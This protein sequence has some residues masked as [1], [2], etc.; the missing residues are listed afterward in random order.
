MGEVWRRI[1]MHPGYEASSLGRVRSV[2]RTL[3]DGRTAGGVVLAQQEDKDGYLRVKLGRK[4]IGVHTLVLLAFHGPPEAR[5]LNGN[6]QD[7]RPT[8]LAWGSRRDNEQDKWKAERKKEEGRKENRSR[9]SEITTSF[10]TPVRLSEAHSLGV[11]TG[12]LESVRKCRHRD[13]TFPRPVAADG[14][15]MLY[16][17][18]EL[19][20][21]DRHRRGL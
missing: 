21:W 17:A 18:A 5:H 3:T 13:E 11:V 15:A 2:D 20:A 16:D 4:L 14:L 6:R 1:P 8:E 19:L 10:R 7:N 9:P 12:S